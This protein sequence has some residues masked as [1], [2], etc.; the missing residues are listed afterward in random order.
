MTM[1]RSNDSRAD[2]SPVPP[3]L[4][5]IE[6][7]MAEAPAASVWRRLIG[8]FALLA[9]A[10]YHL[11]LVVNDYPSLGGGGFGNGL[12]VRWGQ[13]FGQVGLWVARHVFQR[14]GPMPDALRG[15]NGDTT[16]EY[17]RLLAGAAIAVIAAVIWVAADRR[18]PR[19]RWVEAALHV[20]LRYSIALGLASYAVAKL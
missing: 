5:P 19:A 13:V 9:F 16:A 6:A 11:P 8:R 2:A 18:R 20:L 4:V 10:L 3:Q 14:T 17:G 7:A 15:D 12:S 1:T